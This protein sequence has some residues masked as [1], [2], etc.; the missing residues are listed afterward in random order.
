[1]IRYGA[2]NKVITAIMVLLAALACASGCARKPSEDDRFLVKVSDGAITV[3]DF[4]SKI[5][6]L[7]PYYRAFVEKSKVRYLEEMIMEKLF[8]EAA[9]RMGLDRDREVQEVIKEAKKKIIIAR[10][11]ESEVEN[12][13]RV[14][15][16]EIRK[17]YDE[18]KGDFKTPELWR[19]SHILLA[20][21]KEA[22]DTLDALAKG[23]KFEDLAGQK[24]MDATASRGGDIGFFRA[25]QLVPDFERACLKLGV[26]QTSDV[27][28]TQF[29]FHVIR[30]TDKREP[31]TE[32]F[33]KAKGKIE[34]EIKKKKRAELFDKLVTDLKDKYGV[35]I[36]ENVL[37]SID[38]APKDKTS[39]P[40]GR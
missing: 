3:K 23:A 5:E 6:R 15:D 37:A 7:P 34:N 2:M 38:G 39:K 26:G 21:E 25:G 17:Y 9:I 11:V 24:S 36:D 29:G 31:G 33:E 1:M 8:Y 22:R 35:K 18:H 10:L 40:E 13:V 27:V 12:K 32:D 20:T 14:T 28:R 4:K 30:L 16:D 19:A